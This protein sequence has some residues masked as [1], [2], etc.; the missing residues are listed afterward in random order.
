MIEP[1]QIPLVD[2]ATEYRLL[3]KE[4]NPALH[5]VLQKADLILGKEVSRFEEAFARFCQTRHAISVANGTDALTIALLA[6]GVECGDEVITTTNTF[7]GTVNAVARIGAKPV[8]VD[9]DP[10][11]YTIDPTQV[12][13]KIRKRTKAII[14]VHLYGQSADMGPILKLTGRYGLKVIEDACQAHGSLYRGK[15]VG[16]LGDV[17][18][19][20][21]YPSKN[22]GAYGDGGILTTNNQKIAERARSLRHHGE[23]QKG[24]HELKGFNSRLDTVQ[25]AILRVKLNYLN[26]WNVLRRKHATLYT[27]LLKSLGIATPIEAPYTRHVYHVYA[28]RV[29]ERDVMRSY[30]AKEGVSTGIHYPLPIHLQRAYRDLGHRRGD[31]PVSEQLSKEILSLPMHPFLTEEKIRYVC[32]LIEK[33]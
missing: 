2:L 7:I 11:F 12:K 20:S 32:R 17:G 6:C 31:F 13:R 27:K 16:S 9:V 8:L 21:F 24:R 4:L 22:L 18:C 29:K 19:F 30:L 3:R 5:K 15:K 10:V 25:A 28:I 33:F 1:M 23:M 14:P 26:R